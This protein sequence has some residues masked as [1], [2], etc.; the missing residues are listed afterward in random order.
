MKSFEIAIARQ[1][2]SKDGGLVGVDDGGGGCGVK[3]AWPGVLIEAELCPQNKQT[4]RMMTP[5]GVRLGDTATGK[6]DK[7]SSGQRAI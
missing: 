2:K 4:D 1:K 3:S 7:L 6:L 5:D